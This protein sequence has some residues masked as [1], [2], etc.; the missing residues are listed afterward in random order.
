MFAK[1]VGRSTSTR[2]KSVVV[3]LPYVP[4]DG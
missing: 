3:E 2:A 1:Y 4:F